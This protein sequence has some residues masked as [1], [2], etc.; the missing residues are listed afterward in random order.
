MKHDI[1]NSMAN[2]INMNIKHLENISK[3]LRKNIKTEK[4]LIDP[5]R[6]T[7]KAIILLDEAARILKNHGKNKK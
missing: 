2:A 4:W 7:E 6:K 1:A 5:A 3:H